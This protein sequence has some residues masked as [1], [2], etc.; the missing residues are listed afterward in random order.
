[1]IIERN[2]DNGYS[3][4]PHDVGVANHPKV[5][6]IIA[7]FDSSVVSTASVDSESYCESQLARTSVSYSPF[8]LIRAAHC[9]IST[10]T[11]GSIRNGRV[12]TLTKI[13]GMQSS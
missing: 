6:E 11:R 12:T 3:R 4:S 2:G 9:C 1:M 13:R 8:S 7:I 10:E 5:S